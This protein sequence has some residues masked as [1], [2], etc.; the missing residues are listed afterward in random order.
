MTFTAV[1]VLTNS[2]DAAAAAASAEAAYIQ[3]EGDFGTI[4][5]GDYADT[6]ATAMD[7]ALG[8]NNDIETEGGLRWR[9]NSSYR[10]SVLTLST[11]LQ[12][13]AGFQIG[14]S[15]DLTDS[16]ADAT[17]GKTDCGH[18]IQHERRKR[19]LWLTSMMRETSWVFKG[20]VAGFTVA[21]G[22]KTTQRYYTKS[23]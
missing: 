23:Q 22:N 15:K 20:S 1:S 5:L 4:I 3:A 18:N 8:S 12:R 9:R 17:D 19:L 2:S 13:W 21:V 14:V 11:C 6:A 10:L 16:D 7:G